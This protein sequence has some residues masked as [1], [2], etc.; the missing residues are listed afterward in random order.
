LISS[1]QDGQFTG[2]L[3]RRRV[4]R[5]ATNVP[6]AVMTS[7][8]P[9]WAGCRR[10]DSALGAARRS[11]GALPLLAICDFDGPGDKQHAVT[12]LTEVTAG[13]RM[14]GMPKHAELAERA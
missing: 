12:L 10:V 8:P 6:L 2:Q 11:S 14:L 5:T 9:S 7:L 1:A 13:Y 4:P 3:V